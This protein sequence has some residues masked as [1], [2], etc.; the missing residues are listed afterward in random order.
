MQAHFQGNIKLE[1][2]KNNLVNGEFSVDLYLTI[3][4]ALL[5][6]LLMTFEF[7]FSYF[8]QLFHH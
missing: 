5:L 7:P 4:R 1:I 2:G 8:Y 3:P 6:E